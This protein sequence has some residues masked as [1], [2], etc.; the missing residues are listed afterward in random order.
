MEQ[1]EVLIVGAGACGLVAARE[2]LRKG[3]QVTVLE[4]RDR[5]GGRIYTMYD[6]ESAIPLEAGAEF[7]HGN[8]PVTISLLN[9]YKISYAPVAGFFWQPVTGDT[10]SENNLIE[11]H[12]RLLA[13]NLR[14]LKSDMGVDQFL[15]LHFK[16]EKYASM[17]KSVRGFVQGYD[18]AD[19][20]KAS[21]FSF[22]DEW[23]SMDDESQYRIPEGYSKLISEIAAECS[24]MKGVMNLSSTVKKILWKRNHVEAWTE[25]GRVFK[26]GKA[27]VTIPLGVLAA[28]ASKAGI[29]FSPSLDHKKKFFDL[30]GYGTV[31][32]IALTFSHCF[33]KD[34]IVKEK[35][36]KDLSEVGFIFSREVVPTWWT[37]YPAD[38]PLLT[39]WIGGAPAHAIS[40][41]EEKEILAACIKSLSSV[42]QLEISEVEQM[43]LGH[44]FFNWTDDP[45]SLGAYSY[46]VVDS[47]LIANKIKEP[48]EDTIYF[49]GEGLHVGEH[50]GTVE[51]AFS[52]GFRVVRDMS[53]Q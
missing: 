32:K 24:R 29:A 47:L 39:G 6:A 10:S 19:P 53:L 35:A 2:L 16:E 21:T 46:S 42:F 52:E 38:V 12:H 31:L 50:V 3:K 23:L 28:P 7:I 51:A 41:M 30:L 27:I 34:S 33:W 4:A 13:K 14:D 49:A 22:R 26:A 48:E 44:R 45:F 20:S 43:L 25:D 9:E 36:G 40:R 15:E 1:D 5:I 37:Q 11:E 8:L 18:A 17:K